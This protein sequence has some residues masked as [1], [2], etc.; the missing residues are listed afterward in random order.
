VREKRAAGQWIMYYIIPKS[1]RAFVQGK[2]NAEY[3]KINGE[4][5][6]SRLLFICPVLKPEKCCFSAL[7][8]EASG[9][10]K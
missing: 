9:E 10:S 3:I 2:Y 7:P 6:F 4:W 1:D 5:K 8:Q